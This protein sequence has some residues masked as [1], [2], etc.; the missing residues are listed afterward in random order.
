MCQRGP[1]F[2]QRMT[3]A[4][5]GPSTS[6]GLSS[7]LVEGI[8]WAVLRL[9]PGSRLEHVSGLKWSVE[10]LRSLAG[11]C[12]SSTVGDVFKVTLQTFDGSKY[13]FSESARCQALLDA[14][15]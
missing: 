1:R 15:G 13:Y 5:F 8:S 7:F 9:G 4:V 2:S 6:V 12:Y 14:G 11:T 10:W 3:A